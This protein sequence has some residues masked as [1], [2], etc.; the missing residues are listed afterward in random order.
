M[1]VI[2]DIK[3]RIDIV[4]LVSRYV[5]L[6]RAGRSYKACCPFH[7]ERTPSFVVTPDRGT[8]YCFNGCSG[9]KKP[10]YFSMFASTWEHCWRSWW[11]SV[12]K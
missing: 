9:W 2:D 11:S 1:S 5:P 4:D 6:K 7:E 12:R 10:S 3:T 8:W